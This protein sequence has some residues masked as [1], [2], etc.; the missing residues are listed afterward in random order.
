MTESTSPIGPEE[1]TSRIAQMLNPNPMEEDTSA[2]GEDAQ[3]E[4]NEF[5]AEY[6]DDQV[7]ADSIEPQKFRVLNPDTGEEEY[8]TGD[9]LADGWMR[10]KTFTQKTQLLAEQRKE[11]EAE[12]AKVAEERE[13][14]QAGLHQYLSQP[15]PQPPS[16][17]LFETDPLAYMK[18][19]DDYRDL[20]AQRS[21]AQAELQR[22]DG[23][24]MRD[25]NLQ[26]QEYLQ[27]ESEK[28]TNLIPE[29]RDETVATKEKQAIREYGVSL[30]Y[31]AEEMDSI[32]DARAIALMRKSLLF[33]SMTQKGKTKLQRGPEGVATLRPGGQQPQRRV[34]QYRR[35]KMQLAKT[36]KPDDATKAIS[37]ILKRSA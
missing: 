26:R 14:Y 27:R 35:A 7:E 24:R 32:G 23:E 13:Q 17:E 19:K 6:D 9:E 4:E 36:G 25:A 34:S 30:G 12:R 3:L 28:L 15:E 33:D 21:Q 1:A 20:L 22:V 29:W 8:Y 37:E 11:M 31:S 18:A 5:E 2:I 16:E 10:Q